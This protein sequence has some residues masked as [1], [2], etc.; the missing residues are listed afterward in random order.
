MSLA[1]QLKFYRE[2]QGFS[3]NK[4]ADKLNISR[5][6]IS[7]WENGRGYPD[8]DNLVLLSELYKVSIDE[9]L[10]ENEELKAKIKQNNEEIEKNRKKL[11][12]I[13]GEINKKN[14]EGILLLALAA[15]SS[16]IFPVGFIILP[17]ILYRNK[18]ENTLYKL[19]YVVVC[20][21]LL[22]NIYDGYIH[23]AN[24]LNFGDTNIEQIE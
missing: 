18:K 22:L 23:V 11:S 21:A 15:I 1:T 24:Y 19:V 5:Q 6:S 8:L 20:V 2:Q 7:K 4:V 10:H 3:Q 13:D 9:L 16:F 14:D 12:F 17:I